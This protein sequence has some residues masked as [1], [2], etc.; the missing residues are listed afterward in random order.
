MQEFGLQ[1]PCSL[2]CTVSH[3]CTCMHIHRCAHCNLHLR[4]ELSEPMVCGTNQLVEPQLTCGPV[5]AMTTCLWAHSPMGGE[6]HKPYTSWNSMGPVSV[7][8]HCSPIC[9]APQALVT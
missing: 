6:T 7:E 3:L 2:S 8:Q 4:C 1:S 5:L 9:P